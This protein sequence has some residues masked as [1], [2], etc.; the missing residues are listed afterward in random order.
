MRIKQVRVTR[1]NSAASPVWK[2]LARK[3]TQDCREMWRSL[4]I[5]D[6]GQGNLISSW[7]S[8]PQPKPKSVGRNIWFSNK[9]IYAP[10][11]E[12]RPAN[13]EGRALPLHQTTF[14]ASDTTDCW[15]CSSGRNSIASNVVFRQ[16]YWVC[17]IIK[18]RYLACFLCSGVAQCSLARPHNNKRR[19]EERHKDETST[20]NHLQKNNGWSY[21]GKFNS[22][23][24]INETLK[25][26]V[27]R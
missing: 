20:N 6:K 5:A 11:L 19:R 17:A 25:R 3:P 7:A 15:K 13:H 10:G 24:Q 1:V 18:R 2:Y 21:L 4:A 22:A 27:L 23:S 12:P 9:S 16:M 26:S 8:R 14:G